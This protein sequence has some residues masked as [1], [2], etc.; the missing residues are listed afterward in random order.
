MGGHGGFG[1]LMADGSR[2]SR[3]IES[4]YKA[5][6]CP[7]RNCKLGCKHCLFLRNC[8]LGNNKINRRMLLDSGILQEQM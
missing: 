1:T 7:I 4:V 8:N 3:L 5:I 6:K 2:F